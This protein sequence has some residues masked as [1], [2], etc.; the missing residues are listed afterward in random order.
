[1]LGGMLRKRAQPV[2][3]AA[4]WPITATVSAEPRAR[5]RGSHAT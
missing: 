3:E 5:G 1:M 4:T 2:I